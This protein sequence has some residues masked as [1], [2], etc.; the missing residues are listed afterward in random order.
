MVIPS[1]VFLVRVVTCLRVDFLFPVDSGL[2]APAIETRESPLRRLPIQHAHDDAVP[3]DPSSKS[4][5]DVVP[6]SDQSGEQQQRPDLDSPLAQSHSAIRN[7][8]RPQQDNGFSGLGNRAHLEQA[9]PSAEEMC[10]RVGILVWIIFW[11]VVTALK[12]LNGLHS[13]EKSI[14]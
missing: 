1:V 13:I 10:Y 14:S 5:L 3:E 6:A 7:I 8:G 4:R 2:Q 11:L 12:V 9:P